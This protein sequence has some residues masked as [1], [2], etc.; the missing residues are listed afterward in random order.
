MNPKLKRLLPPLLTLI[1]ACSIIAVWVIPQ[2]ASST[3]PPQ[4][5]ESDDLLI[6][7]T[8]TWTSVNTSNASGGSYL[9]ASSTNDTLTLDF[10]GTSIEVIYVEAPSFGSFTVEI[11]NTAVRTVTAT[12]ASTVFDVHSVFEYLDD[13]PHTLRIMGIQGT[14]A[15]DAFYGVPIE[16]PNLLTFLDEDFDDGL[17]P[18]WVENAFG[19]EDFILPSGGGYALQLNGSYG[20]FHGQGGITDIVMRASVKIESGRAVFDIN[21]SESG[22]YQLIIESDGTL[23]LHRWTTTLAT[24]SLPAFSSTQWFDLEWQNFGGRLK[25]FIDDELVLVAFDP[26]ALPIGNFEVNNDG[27]FKQFWVDDFQVLLTETEFTDLF[28]SP[29]STPP[30]S[31]ATPT[32]TLTPPPGGSPESFQT[33]NSG[34]VLY[35]CNYSSTSRCIK[36]VDNGTVSTLPLGNKQIADADW[37]PSGEEIIYLRS[38]QG[39]CQDAL[40]LSYSFGRLVKVNDQWQDQ[41]DFATPPVET[42]YNGC[43]YTASISGVI[44]VSPDG[45]NVAFS[46][47]FDGGNISSAI[48]ILDLNNCSQNNCASNTITGDSDPTTNDYDP[49]WS[50]DGSMLAFDSFRTGSNHIHTVNALGGAITPIPYTATGYGNP[51]WSSK[52]TLAVAWTSI[53]TTG[54]WIYQRRV[55]IIGLDGSIIASPQDTF[56]ESPDYRL[57][58]PF[59]SWSPDGNRFVYEKAFSIRMFDLVTATDTA[60]SGGSRPRWWGDACPSGPQESTCQTEEPPFCILAVN[61]PQ[62]PV[63]I[64]GYLLPVRARTEHIEFTVLNATGPYPV[65]DDSAGRSYLQGTQLRIEQRYKYFNDPSSDEYT[66]ERIVLVTEINDSPAEITKY[67]PNEDWEPAYDYGSSGDPDYRPVWIYD[68]LDLA[69]PRTTVVVEDVSGNQISDACNYLVPSG[70]DKATMDEFG[71]TLYYV[72]ELRLY[73][74]EAQDYGQ[75]LPGIPDLT[76]F[77]QWETEELQ[78]IY[79]SVQDTADMFGSYFPGEERSHLF[80]TIMGDITIIKHGISE[81][82]ITCTSTVHEDSSCLDLDRR[83]IEFIPSNYP[84]NQLELDPEPGN[85]TR[86]LLVYYFGLIFDERIEEVTGDS[87]LRISQLVQANQIRDNRDNF[88]DLEAGYGVYHFE[89]ILYADADGPTLYFYYG[90][91]SGNMFVNFV[92]SNFMDIIYG[93]HAWELND[94]PRGEAIYDYFFGPIRRRPI[95]WYVT[96]DGNRVEELQDGPYDREL[97]NPIDPLCVDLRLPGQAR[98]QWMDDSMASIF[99]HEA[100]TTL[101]ETGE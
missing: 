86:E 69:S 91:F 50:P 18:G 77:E 37:L 95:V 89:G 98:H 8:G 32:P 54:S 57:P 9:Y 74:I 53:D 85:F 15:I 101:L 51:D 31:T 64:I 23:T 19:L 90:G 88:V 93:D 3:D 39:M 87:S 1:V 29:P 75:S 71:S 14:V 82:T 81:R 2:P 80:H 49:T 97:L 35:R 63:G 70:P 83:I 100:W 25:V 7:Q 26:D 6:F 17:V 22:G 10:Y 73:G 21:Q 55:D 40:R 96:A 36:D 13:G 72:E 48:W 47:S 45:T 68:G 79:E 16:P 38:T 5:I 61:Q 58:V 28:G 99:E 52:N 62:N 34:Q 65:G 42:T 76:E 84:Y 20:R 27:T 12:G 24:A 43:D 30:P 4:T 59:P 67:D 44:A 78:V 60:F 66:D 94:C 56:I 92:Y 41:G 46:A 33:Q 11:D